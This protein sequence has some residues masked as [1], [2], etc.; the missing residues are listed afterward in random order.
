MKM[1][2]PLILIVDD[3]PGMLDSLSILL[4]KDFNILTASNGEEGLSV[5]KDNPSISMILLDM[6]MPVMNGL[7]MLIKIR[8]TSDIKVVIMTGRSTH[9]WAMKCADL[10]VQGYMNKPVDPEK[11]INRLK[12]LLSIDDYQVLREILGKEYE[13][14]I[15]SMNPIVKNTLHYIEKNSPINFNIK[16]IAI[17]LDITHEYLSRI[18]HKECKVQLK[19]YIKRIKIEKSKEYLAR[20]P[21]LNIK[22][23]ATSA[24][25][26]N[27]SNFYRLFKQYTN[28]TPTQF[29][30]NLP[31]S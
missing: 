22:D 2:K 29:R 25:I 10:N 9:E 30:K 24:G 17:H 12:E 13:T 8:E 7:E 19:D 3:E 15:F 21:Y 4:G 26:N 11:L 5:F 6:D 27:E 31:L 16:Q 23:V 1:N 28:V 18:F 20:K 14:Q